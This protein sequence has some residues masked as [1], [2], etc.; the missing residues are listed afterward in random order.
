MIEKRRNRANLAVDP[1]TN[2]A[3]DL[4]SCSP[5]VE[6]G[7]GRGR[8]T[9]GN[10]PRLCRREAL[11]GVLRHPG[12]VAQRARNRFVTKIATSNE[13]VNFHCLTER[14]PM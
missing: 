2:P 3:P 8:K 10:G 14:K 7:K 11:T 1:S 12:Q 13:A 9:D 4:R 5:H 6:I